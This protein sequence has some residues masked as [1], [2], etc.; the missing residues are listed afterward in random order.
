MKRLNFIVV[1]ALLVG[2]ILV[3]PFSLAEAMP[4]G[5]TVIPDTFTDEFN[6]IP[7]YGNCSLREALYTVIANSDFGGCIHT[8]SW[9]Y[10]FVTLAHGTYELTLSGADDGIQAGDLDLQA[11]YSAAPGLLAPLAPGYDITISGASDGSVIDA[12]HI[13][14][15]MEFEG[16]V[17]VYLLRIMVKGGLSRE[18]DR[19][20]GGIYIHNGASVYL[21][22]SAVYDNA[23]YPTGEGGGVVNSGTL[24]VDGSLIMDN[25]TGAGTNDNP[26]GLGGGIVN[27]NSLHVN[28]TSIQGNWTG[29]NTGTNSSGKAAGL[30]N[31]GTATLNR[32]TITDNHVGD[33]TANSIYAN[34]GDGGGI[35][36][37]G[38]LTINTS[39]IST[40]SAGT[41]SFSSP[42]NGGGIYNIGTLDVNHCTIALNQAGY[43]AGDQAGGIINSG[44]SA[45]LLNTIVAG[46]RAEFYPDLYGS[47]ISEDYLLIQTTVGYTFTSGP[48]D[49]N[50]Y[51]VDP[52]LGPLTDLGGVGWVHYLRLGS[53]AIDAGPIT[54]ISHDERLLSRPKDGDGNGTATCDIGAFEANIW[55]FFPLLVKP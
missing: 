4:L 2:V 9:G 54:C 1:L 11:D 15:V 44:S 6:T 14:R 53:P 34:G 22:D 35:Y 17:S 49:N 25:R 38:T 41:S 3:Q 7:P 20:G 33:A 21:I 42:G 10:D 18:A 31:S 5:A 55:Q 51:G 26:S 32:V 46:N 27:F 48:E 47:F 52:L 37:S 28:D 40:N 36:N 8:G 29:I 39:T 12:N 45:S 30:Y 50:Q 19:M 13:D 16:G 24:T 43:G 23:T